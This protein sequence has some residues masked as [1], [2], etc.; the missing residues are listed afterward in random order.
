MKHLLLGPLFGLLFLASTAG[1]QDLPYYQEHR[2]VVIFNLGD[3][4]YVTSWDGTRTLALQ[5]GLYRFDAQR[6]SQSILDA[7]TLAD[8]TGPFVQYGSTM[9]GT[10][11]NLVT[12]TSRDLSARLKLT[13]TDLSR[14]NI[15][16]AGELTLEMRVQ[17][18]SMSSTQTRHEGTVAQDRAWVSGTLDPAFTSQTGQIEVYHVKL[19]LDDDHLAIRKPD[20]FF[21]ASIDAQVTNVPATEPDWSHEIEAGPYGFTLSR[22]AAN[23]AGMMGYDSTAQFPMVNENDYYGYYRSRAHDASVVVK[24]DGDVWIRLGWGLSGRYHGWSY[25]TTAT[26]TRSEFDT[27]V[28]QGSVTVSGET[29]FGYSGEDYAVDFSTTAQIE[30]TIPPPGPTIATVQGNVEVN[31]GDVEIDAHLISGMLTEALRALEGEPVTATG[32]LSAPGEL[33]V[34]SFSTPLRRD[35]RGIGGGRRVRLTAGTQVEVLR[36]WARFARVRFDDNGRPRE[37]TIRLRSV[38]PTNSSGL[39]GGV[40]TP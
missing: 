11:T 16:R 9:S 38:V 29:S 15:V 34:T 12:G 4:L 25:E 27:L 13:D 28:A 31:S 33:K 22:E 8:G 37:V 18:S 32:E 26:L 17:L 7:D 39:L 19:T 24:A 36:T 1:A 20:D 6:Q 3:D 2:L 35:A 10:A 23:R 5:E 14:T 30:L 21:P 40:S